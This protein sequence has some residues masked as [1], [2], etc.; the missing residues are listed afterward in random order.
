MGKI[1][2]HTEKDVQEIEKRKYKQGEN[3]AIWDYL[4]KLKKEVTTLKRENTTLKHK[5]DKVK[6]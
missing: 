1:V 2:V 3:Q 6:K 4:D 5:L